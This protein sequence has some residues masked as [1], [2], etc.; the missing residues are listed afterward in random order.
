MMFQILVATTRD[1]KGV[2]DEH[3]VVQDAVD[4]KD[5]VS[6][7]TTDVIGS[8]AFGLDCNSLQ[9][10]NSE[11]R[12]YGQKLLKRR[13]GIKKLLAFIIGMLPASIDSIFLF[14]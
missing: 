5:V 2:L 3:S 7:F 9:N 14:T 13:G 8:C 4:I 11:F 1:L 6:R 12:L 10:P